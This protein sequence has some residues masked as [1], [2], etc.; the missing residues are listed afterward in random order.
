MSK[1]LHNQ[2]QSLPIARSPFLSR[3]I[4]KGK[5]KSKPILPMWRE[6]DS[7][8]DETVKV[9]F[10]SRNARRVT[11]QG[12]NLRKAIIQTNS[13]KAEA[14]VGENVQGEGLVCY[15]EKSGIADCATA[16]SRLSLDRKSRPHP[17]QKY[18]VTAAS[19]D[20]ATLS[21]VLKAS[22]Q[23]Q[24][25][26]GLEGTEAPSEDESTLHSSPR[27]HASDASEV[28]DHWQL[29]VVDSLDFLKL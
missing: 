19:E 18:V 29:S 17:L 21:L 13:K 1:I 11:K 20:D 2:K 22:A 12:T 8:Q 28:D 3:F 25:S 23:R 26:H 9:W 7:F 14:W 5:P 15:V 27:S 24:P 6:L 4:P 10:V 16:E